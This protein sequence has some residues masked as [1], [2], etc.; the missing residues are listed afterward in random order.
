MRLSKISIVLFVFIF[1]GNSI[2][3]QEI[4]E[5]VKSK[6]LAR[7]KTLV[8]KN[9]ELV[10]SKDE[11][12]K[13]PLFWACSA[14]SEEIIK[15]LIEKGADINAR[16][17]VASIPLHYLAYNG[18]REIVN[19]LIEKGADVNA[20]H[21][22]GRTALFSAAGGNY[23][24]NVELIISKGA[25]V[26]EPD[27]LGNTALHI[28]SE[29]G[30]IDGVK[31]L[32]ENGAD[33]NI[34]NT[35][36]ESAVFS[37]AKSGQ[38]EVMKFLISEGADINSRGSREATLLHY[39]S[40]SSSGELMEYFIQN[41][42]SVN[43]KE[44]YGQTPLFYAVQG[45]LKDNVEYLLKNNAEVNIEDISG[46]T[47]LNIAEDWGNS[48]M[49]NL[50]KSKGAKSFKRKTI[51]IDSKTSER[52]KLIEITFVG[53]AGYLIS[54]GR[55]KILI[56][57]LQQNPYGSDSTPEPFF[58]KMKSN[59]PPFDNVNLLLFSHGHSDH[60][61]S[62]MAMDLMLGNSSLEMAGPDNTISQLIE[63]HPENYEKIK[64]RVFNIN[65]DW[66]KIVKK[67]FRGLDFEIFGVNHAPPDRDKYL[68]I[69]FI[70]RLSGKNIL[71]V[72]DLSPESCE[73]YFKSV[74]P[75]DR[76]IDIAFLD[77]YFL[78]NPAGQKILENYI[79]PKKI[80][81]THIRS[82]NTVAV[83][84]NIKNKYSNIIV[85]KNLMVKE[86]FE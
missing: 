14:V 35:A 39:A 10:N 50:L 30:K 71:Y 27:F 68:T 63:G 7:V 59:Q 28:V 66:N 73:E 61:N 65:P 83:E 58:N 9:P 15:H 38:I 19:Y 6:N 3:A 48:E 13:T 41:G 69:C 33:L 22:L 42:I 2:F 57:G 49:I 44:E 31:I 40:K 81:V 86:I 79:Q 78:V 43:E 24:E 4:F 26:N 52:G 12:G 16:D 23:P 32:L 56:D 5:A 77:Q 11:S 45:N 25:N 18:D 74:N 36:G 37:A 47:P 1:L 8:E 82:E 75:K 85:F 76:N 70:F 34:K 72:G 80:I 60:F 53:N 55:I 29:S 64:K 62:E 54:D 84:K 51:K 67:N 46:K 21:G 20:K 17:R